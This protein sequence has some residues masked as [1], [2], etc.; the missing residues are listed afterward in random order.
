MERMT[1]EELQALSPSSMEHIHRYL[2]AKVLARGSVLDLACGIGYGAKILLDNPA[3]SN[4]VGA[5]LA[6]DA[7]AEAQRTA[8]THARFVTGSA[9][10]LPFE[11]AAFDAIV[12]LETLEHLEDPARAVAEFRRVLKPQG[13]LVGSVP[14]ASFEDFCTGQYGKNRYHLQKFSAPEL[15]QLLIAAFPQVQLFVARVGIA[16]ALFDA[17]GREGPFHHEV[18]AEA[19]GGG[20]DYGSYLFVAADS[21]LPS[22]LAHQMGVLLVGGSYF[23]AESVELER[24]LGAAMVESFYANLISAKDQLIENKEEQLRKAE[25]LVLARGEQLRKAETQVQQAE[26]QKAGLRSALDQAEAELTRIKS[27]RS[28]RLVS[29]LA[30]V[31]GLLRGNALG[32]PG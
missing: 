4:Y 21:P 13:V 20:H 31:R 30:R 27:S 19:S 6:E 2:C 24:R 25:T 15:E 18:V 14:T 11:H 12:S 28:W 17:T 29:R 32:A 8:P 10:D 26:A 3:V 16:A 1:R 23:E 7:L 22:D 5:D 9:L